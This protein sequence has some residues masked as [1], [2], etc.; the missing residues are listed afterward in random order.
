MNKFWAVTLLMGLG[1][2]GCAVDESGYRHLMR[3]LDR[4]GSLMTCEKLHLDG[5]TCLTVK[6]LPDGSDGPTVCALRRDRAAELAAEWIEK[7]VPEGERL[8]P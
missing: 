8:T 2:S 1:L 3:V 5:N 7:N 6:N 4:R